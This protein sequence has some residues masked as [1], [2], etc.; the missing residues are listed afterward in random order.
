[1]TVNVEYDATGK[2][3]YLDDQLDKIAGKS[4]GSAGCWVF[5]P[6][7]IRDRQYTFGTQEEAEKVAAEMRKVE[8]VTAE[9][10]QM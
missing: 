6:P 1:M 5:S 10:T 8:G 3:P 9:V 7:H 4:A 2:G